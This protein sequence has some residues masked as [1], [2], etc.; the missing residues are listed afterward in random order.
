M[1]KD[2]IKVFAVIPSQAPESSSTAKKPDAL[3]ALS[4]ASVSFHHK[5][6]EKRRERG[7]HEN[8]KSCLLRGTCTA[9]Y[10]TMSNPRVN[11][12]LKALLLAAMIALA[13]S[14][15]S[16]PAGAVKA[17]ARRALL[18]YEEGADDTSELGNSNEAVELESHHAQV[19]PSRHSLTCDKGP[20]ARNRPSR[21]SNASVSQTPLLS[22]RTLQHRGARETNRRTPPKERES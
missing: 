14:A 15:R 5:R 20:R 11:T 19:R 17:D 12:M 1:V 4:S 2:G 3:S 6:K 10:A 21:D 9:R 13:S 22:V 7:A 18:E 16:F 8:A